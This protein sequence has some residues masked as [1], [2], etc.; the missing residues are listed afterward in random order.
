M[1]LKPRKWR[2]QEHL[3]HIRD[4]DWGPMY[5]DAGQELWGIEGKH[6][7]RGYKSDGTAIGC[8]FIR[9]QPGASFPLHTHEGDHEIYFIYGAGVVHIN[10]EDIFVHRGHMIH[11]P[12][13]YPHAVSVPKDASTEMV[14]A[15]AGHPHHHVDSSKR[16]T[17][18]NPKRN[19]FAPDKTR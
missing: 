7:V 3:R 4:G 18:I 9:M 1:D 15:A 12:A 5:D 13:E 6:G 14:F 19:R 2:H 11:I 16:L 8:D 10:G 17:V